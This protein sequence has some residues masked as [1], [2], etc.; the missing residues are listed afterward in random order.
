M[1]KIFFGTLVLSAIVVA[2]AVAQA[3]VLPTLPAMV[4]PSGVTV[5]VPEVAI[6]NSLSLEP[7]SLERVVFIHYAN[8]RVVARAKAFSCYK[9]LGVKWRTLPVNYVVHPDLESKVAGAIEASA[10]TWDVATGKELFSIPTPDTSANW[11]GD[12]PDGKNEYSLGPYPDP[13]VIAVT[14][15][16]SGIKIGEKG[17]QIIEY[18]VMFNNH[19]AWGDSTQTGTSTMDLQNISTHETG[20]GL[21]LGDIY[22]SACGEVTMYGYSINGETK[23]RTL[24]TPD[25]LGLQKMYG[26]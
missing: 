23:K 4:A 3:V 14:V 2:G 20:H 6:S 9:L 26:I 15:I 25:I 24:E 19:F 21:G 18:D 16:W 10:E 12:Y 22:D 11:D 5:S 1:K 17:R 8:G 13:S 7:G